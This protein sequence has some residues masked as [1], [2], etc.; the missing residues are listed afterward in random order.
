M[1]DW[2]KGQGAINHIVDEATALVQF[3]LIWDEKGPVDHPLEELYR[4]KAEAMVLEAIDHFTRIEG[5]LSRPEWVVKVSNGQV[6]FSPDQVELL[7]SEVGQKV[8]MHRLKTGKPSKS[9]AK[10]PIYPLYEA[11]VKYAHPG[12][13]YEVRLTYLGNK[14]PEPSQDPFSIVGDLREYEAAIVGIH[15]SDFSPNPKDKR[16]CPGCPFYFICPA[17]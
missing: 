17:G 7:E 14:K 13:D 2:L 4:N 9:E 6:R 16:R 10:K 5:K 12:I 15:Q 11:G 3:S 8:I 1:I